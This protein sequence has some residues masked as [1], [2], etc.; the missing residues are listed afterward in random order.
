MKVKYRTA[1]KE[2]SYRIAELDYIASGGAAE[3]LFH[4]LVPNSTP[5]QVVAYGLE[6]DSY[7]HSYRSAIVAELNNKIIGMSLS[8]PS[9]FHCINDEMRKFFPPERLEHFKEF[10]SAR[11]DNSYLVDA[12]CVDEEY[13]SSGIGEKLLQKIIEKAHS[14]GFSLL[15][16]LVFSDN[17]KAIKF[18]TAHGFTTEREVELKEHKLIPHKGGCLLMKADI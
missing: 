2:D 15:S 18:Y 4:D 14:E 5:V 7:P 13:R 9:E 17:H 10:F 11:V 16:L 1:R 3:Y 8:F 6:N 12:I